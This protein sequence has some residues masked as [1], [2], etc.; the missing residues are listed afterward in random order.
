MTMQRASSQRP[1]GA[2]PRLA[3]KQARRLE[4]LQ[5]AWQIADEQGL[6]AVSLHEVARRVGLRQP[7]LYA[8]FDS[9]SAL[10]D[11]MYAQGYETLLERV[12]SAA[13]SPDPRRAVAQTAKIIIDFQVSEPAKGQLLFLRTVPGFEPSPESYALAQR[14]LDMSTAQLMAAGASDPVHVDIYTALISGIVNQQTANDPGG[15]RWTRHLETVLDMYFALLDG[16]L[17]PGAPRSTTGS[18]Q[19][20][21]PSAPR[22]GSTSS[23]PDRS[24]SRS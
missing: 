16:A 11:L 15:S 17:G 9:K 19:R 23:A 18:A 21:V 7:S 24:S 13:L 2:D 1:D 5:A 22:R 20:S 3:R 6:A 10:Y 4:I 12:E 8:Y 14:L